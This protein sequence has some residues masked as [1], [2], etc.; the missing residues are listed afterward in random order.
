MSQNSDILNSFSIYLEV[1]IISCTDHWAVSSITSNSNHFTIMCIL[2]WFWNIIITSS[3]DAWLEVK[4]FN[5][6]TMSTQDGE[7]ATCTYCTCLQDTKEII[8]WL[9]QNAINFYRER[10]QDP[11]R[12]KC[13]IKIQNYRMNKAKQV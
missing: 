4:P 6:T 2:S 3:A 12:R 8:R 1:T 5:P 10:S 13:I 7:I 11:F 9:I